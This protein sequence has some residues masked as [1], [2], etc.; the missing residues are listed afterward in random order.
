[1]HPV[2][3]GHTAEDC[4]K[5]FAMQL[6]DWHNILEVKNVCLKKCK[7]YYHSECLTT[8]ENHR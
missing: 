7:Y 4:L 3:S 8:K 1:M 6:G 5:G 2:S